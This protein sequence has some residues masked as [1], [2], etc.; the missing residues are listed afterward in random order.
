MTDI[1]A[2]IKEFRIGE[3]IRAQRQLRR[4]TLQELSDLTGLSKPLLS[5]I[6][7]EQVVPP[8]ATLLKISRGLKVD[9]HFFFE[10]ETNR[11]KLVVTRG[12]ELRPDLQRQAVNAA[13][14]PYTY[15]SLAQGMRHKN[16]E[17]FLVEVENT[18]WDDKLFFRHDGEEEFLYVA[19]GAINFHYGSEVYHLK[20]GD[21]AYYDSSQPHGLVAVGETKA[22]IVAVLYSKG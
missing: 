1:K 16:M 8:L 14:R 15:H 13:V 4:L 22:R 18:T 21:S 12:E 7:N 2:Q 5:Q 11:Q 6:E 3:K 20:A 10:D 17:P 19:D 9:I